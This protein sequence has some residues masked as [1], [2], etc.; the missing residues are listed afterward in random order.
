M[1]RGYMLSLRKSRVIRNNDRNHAST[2]R[3]FPDTPCGASVT[4]SIDCGGVPSPDSTR[5]LFSSSG[6]KAVILLVFLCCLAALVGTRS[7]ASLQGSDFPHFYCAA[8]MLADGHGHQLYDADIQRR[9]QARYAGRIGTLYTHPPFE[10]ALYLAVA[11]LPLR[12]AYVLWS[13]LLMAFLVPAAGRL[14][15][16]ALVPWDWR[17]LL[18]GTLTFVP[19]LVC[20]LQGQDSLILL[21]LVVLAFTDLRREKGFAA[22]CWLALGLFKFQI[23]LPL[24]LVLVLTQSRKLTFNFVKGLGLTALALTGVSI[25]ISGWS[26][27]TLY[28]EFLLHFKEQPLGGLAPQ[29]MPNF[30]GL[31]YLISRNDRSFFEVAALITLS[32]AAL[33]ATLDTWKRARSA[34]LRNPANGR[35]DEFD[36]AFGNTVLFALLVSYHL[37]PHDLSLVLLPISLMLYHGFV[38]TPRLPRLASWI[39]TVLIGILFLPPLHL[40]TL[41]AGVYGLVSLPLLALFLSGAFLARRNPAV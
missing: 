12:Y 34:S 7:I 32:A 3:A 35:G 19:S 33:I 30:R 10:A 21:M 27:L 5:K 17:F 11:W 6:T 40:Y 26:V 14:A 22:G 15:R 2:G 24:T 28:P 23:V 25:A 18:V 20:L 36:L 31:L 29:A 13:L 8:R 39:T 41:G 9:Y 16:D 4:A 38:G 37:N 1:G